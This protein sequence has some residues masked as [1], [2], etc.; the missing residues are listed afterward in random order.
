M[1]DSPSEPDLTSSS[2]RRPTRRLGVGSR[3]VLRYRDEAGSLTDALGDLL[4]Y[5]DETAVVRTRRGEVRV[6]RA[7][8]VTGKEVPPAPRRPG[9]PHRVIEA[10]D[11]QEVMVSG[12]P[13]LQSAWLGRWLL[14]AADGYTGRANSVLPL[15]DPD[16]PL[17][18]A[19]AQAERWY[20]ERSLVP[21]MQVYGST[22]QGAYADGVG[23]LL[24]D[25]GWQPQRTTLVMTAAT[26]AVAAATEP[27]RT[28]RVRA[29]VDETWLSGATQREQ[30]HAGTL[31]AVLERI[32]DAR[33]VTL[34]TD[35]IPDA[36]GRL[37]LA[38]GWAGIFAVHVQPAQRRQG[39]A[40][41]AVGVLAREAQAAGA[42]SIYLQV[43]EA[44]E[45]AVRLYSSLG[46][47]THHEYAYAPLRSLDR[48]E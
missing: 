15:G 20:A 30:E 28:P 5:D 26:D 42:R 31:T 39:L 4:S 1:D 13:P 22:V 34:G 14:R 3:V 23:R 12:M 48:L 45:P 41:E 24:A 8:I 36:I 9:P 44:N 17:A 16:A 29:R 33:Y 46:F 21:M 10:A 6:P 35:R 27:P 38:R 47:R 43:E 32:Q 2:A 11:L 18:E 25:A 7:R 19:V 40:R 37:A